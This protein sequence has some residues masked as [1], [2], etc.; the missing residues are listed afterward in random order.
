MRQ[1]VRAAATLAIAGFAAASASCALAQI[2]PGSDR[3]LGLT[4]ADIP[5]ILKQV[6]ADPY[7]APA[8]PAC[9][10]IPREILALDA[11]L[12]P[13]VD[14]PVKT[15]T[16]ATVANMASGAVRGM[17]P[18]RGWVRFLTQA[19]EKDTKLQRA[20]TAGYARRGFLRGLEANLQCAAISPEGVPASAIVADNGRPA[21]ERI[22]ARMVTKRPEPGDRAGAGVDG[23]DPAQPRPSP[24]V[25][26]EA[27]FQAPPGEVS[28]PRR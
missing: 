4:G 8:E 28:D 6:Q 13:D 15:R 17:I 16:S 24:A 12:G 18:Y 27:P 2:K 3:G 1:T 7:R 14:N 10:S 19:G 26:I 11:I 9:E 5:P 22:A 23:A 20:A 21:G 25:L